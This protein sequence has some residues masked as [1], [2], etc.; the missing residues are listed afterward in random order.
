[1]QK[2]AAFTWSSV[3]LARAINYRRRVSNAAFRSMSACCNL[4]QSPCLDRKFPMP[5]DSKL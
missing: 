3:M 2:C 4:I 1:M 5:F